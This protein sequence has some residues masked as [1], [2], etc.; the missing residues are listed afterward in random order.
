MGITF[1]IGD[2]LSF[3]PV[4]SSQVSVAWIGNNVRSRAR[5]YRLQLFRRT[6]ENPTPEVEITSIDFVSAITGAAPF[7]IAI[8]VNALPATEA[9]VPGG[10][11][12]G[13][14]SARD[15]AKV[16]G[17]ATA[18][19]RFA[20]ALVFIEDRLESGTSRTRG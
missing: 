11:T 7:L 4:T 9:V 10:Q 17:V 8:T 20:E 14:L 2:S 15:F 18:Q 1:G 5:N 19:G 12:D 3:C 13:G 6:W 16:I